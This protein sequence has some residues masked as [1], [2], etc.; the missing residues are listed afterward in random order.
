MTFI[1][2]RRVCK[3]CF[4]FT[5]DIHSGED[6][7][8]HRIILSY[9]ACKKYLF[10][11]KSNQ[12]NFFVVVVFVIFITCMWVFVTFQFNSTVPYYTLS[13][14]EKKYIRKINYTPCAYVRIF[15]I[16]PVCLKSTKS[17]FNPV[18]IWQFTAPDF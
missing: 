6:M 17:Y 7:C 16:F 10:K 14:R 13:Y 2:K 12:S 1:C 15:P 9:H 5:S 11:N 18:S 8:I 3:F 4:P